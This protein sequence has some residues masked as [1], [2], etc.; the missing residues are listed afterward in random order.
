MQLS[1]KSMWAIESNSIEQQEMLLGVDNYV[2][3]G[4][5]L[6]LMNVLMLDYQVEYEACL[7]NK[8]YVGVTNSLHKIALLYYKMHQL[9]LATNYS[10]RMRNVAEKFHLKEQ[11]LFALALLARISEEKGELK[12]AIK[13]LKN[14]NSM[15][16]DMQP[17]LGSIAHNL[18]TLGFVS[19]PL[20]DSLV[21]D[22]NSENQVGND[23]KDSPI[24]IQQ[25]NLSAFQIKY[26]G[27]VVFVVG[28]LILG[29]W[30]NRMQKQP[31][32][33][34]PILISDFHTD[35]L[36]D[37][38]PELKA[39]NHSKDEDI[40]Q[41]KPSLKT[42]KTE[43]TEKTG[44]MEKIEISQKQE[45][46]SKSKPKKNALTPELIISKRSEKLFSE[47]YPVNKV[48][49]WVSSIQH[50]LHDLDAFNGIK[51]DF[52]FLGDFS[53]I[54]ESTSDIISEFVVSLSNILVDANNVQSVSTQLVN[55]LDGFV[56]ILTSRPITDGEPI[57]NAATI[58]SIEKVF[59]GSE[60]INVTS[61]NMP[62]GLLKFVLKQY[63]THEE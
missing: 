14:Y 51:F 26:M 1:P 55:S 58:N 24:E 37:V 6:Q 31:K 12:L 45:T 20:T 2:I 10:W 36:L 17:Q 5:T 13:Y 35:K 15:L 16:K 43:K 27:W 56:V 62:E 54:K 30:V 7:A 50:H 23:V 3:T 53:L 28:I 63:A 44:K 52:N 49:L 61:H 8:N 39:Q 25:G 42:E 38:V 41:L 4:D 9:D 48:P 60:N 29:F 21:N 33:L 19:V 46:P 32:T 57:L 11:E 59:N 40:I 34:N 47:T 18:D 22:S